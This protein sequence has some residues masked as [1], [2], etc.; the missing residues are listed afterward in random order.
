[1]RS[2]RG[3]APALH[4]GRAQDGGR[5]FLRPGSGGTG[6]RPPGRRSVGF[7]G[8]QALGVCSERQD[9]PRR[10]SPGSRHPSGFC[11]RTGGCACG[12][13]ETRR[14]VHHRSRLLCWCRLTWA[15]EV[16]LLL[17]HPI[18]PGLPGDSDPPSMTTTQHLTFTFGSRVLQSASQHAPRGR[19]GSVRRRS[20]GGRA[21]PRAAHRGGGPVRLL[22][23]TLTADG[24]TGELRRCQPPPRPATHGP[25]A[26]TERG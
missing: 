19:G 23:S 4:R 9:V 24:P 26:D 15:G 12:C 17:D 3:P 10:S 13:F 22:A 16:L 25:G 2:I 14:W 11:R 18:R 5:V 20:S 1:M 8:V 6:T 21:A 7:A